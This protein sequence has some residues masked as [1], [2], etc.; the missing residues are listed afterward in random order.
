MTRV[1][2]RSK[3]KTIYLV[4]HAKAVSADAGI[5]D[6]KRALSKQG[7]EDAL[8]VCTRLKHKGVN[9]DILISSPADR[10]LETAHIFAETFGY[11]FHD[12]LLK[13]EIYEEDEY[14]LRELITQTDDTYNTLMLFGHEPNISQ[15]AQYFLPDFDSEMRTSGVVGIHFE[16]AHWKVLESGSGTLFLF[17]FPIRLTPKMYKRARKALK[18]DVIS[19]MESM[20]DH[21]EVEHSKRLEKIIK[22]TSKKLSKEMLKVLQGY[23]LREL[24]RKKKE[25]SAFD[26]LGSL[27]SP[28][29]ASH[30]EDQE[31]S[32][33]PGYVDNHSLAQPRDVAEPPVSDAVRQEE[34]EDHT[35]VPDATRSSKTS[36]G[37]LPAPPPP[38]EANTQAEIEESAEDRPPAHDETPD[39]PG[40]KTKSSQATRSKKT[41]TAQAT[42][43]KRTSTKQDMTPKEDT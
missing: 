17:D 10:A 38:T 37:S 9:P 19:T 14:G 25:A 31:S 2:V 20:L 28:P 43:R 41:T 21:V 33:K 3:M 8:A 27:K 36:N 32:G 24:A 5:N 34:T 15:T 16:A 40:Q 18:K 22:K 4:R 6:F 35:S 13:E 11:P 23:Q 26:V 39:K 29:T 1:S 42:R 7:R 30:D 12:I